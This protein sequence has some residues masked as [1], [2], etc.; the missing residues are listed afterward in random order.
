MKLLH[1]RKFVLLFC[2]LTFIL[3]FTNQSLAEEKKWVKAYSGEYG[4][5]YYNPDSLVVSKNYDGTIEYIKIWVKTVLTPKGINEAIKEYKLKGKKPSSRLVRF[6]IR[7]KER[8]ILWQNQIIYNSKG[9]IIWEKT[10]DYNR[11]WITV[12]PDSGNERYYSIIVDFVFHDGKPVYLN[13]WKNKKDRWI[14]LYGKQNPNGTLTGAFFDSFSLELNGDKITIWE[15][16]ILG[17]KGHLKEGSYIQYTYNLSDKKRRGN[18]ISVWD[19]SKG[20]YLNNEEL[21]GS[22][23]PIIPDSVG[24]YMFDKISQYVN[25]NKQ[26]ILENNNF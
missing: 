3:S 15:H 23:E 18:M 14:Y 6:Y 17:Y 5:D 20:Q 16:N 21:S 26:K 25:E 24:E 19:N 1:K 8:E 7:P 4:S 9:N 10:R 12:I 11:D 13:K 2:I 22:W